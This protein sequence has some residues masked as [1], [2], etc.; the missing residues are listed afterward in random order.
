ML[1]GPALEKAV[2]EMLAR[3]G[4]VNALYIKK[5]AAQVK[6]I[7][8]LNPSSVNRLVA[9]ARM[10]ADIGEIEDLL[11]IAIGANNVQLKALFEKAMEET[12]QDPRFRVYLDEN[13]DALRP[14][15]KERVE[16]YVQTVYRQTAGNMVNL[17]NT[18]VMR[19]AYREAIDR[20]VL[21]TS[22]GVASYTEAMRDTIKQLGGSGLQVQYASGHKRRLDTAVR[23]N[24]VD[25]VNQIN[26]T[27]SV[28][29]GE[30]L[31]YDAIEISAHAKSAPDHEPVQGRVFM[32]AEYEKMQAGLPF[33]DIDGRQ[34]E[35]FKRPIGEWNCR[36]T[37]LAFSTQ[38]SKRKW[39]D[40]QLAAFRAENQQG[41]EIDGK[42]KTQYEAMQMMRDI[43]TEV[44]RQKDI[45]VSA[46]AAGDKALR[47]ECQ[48]NINALVRR[49][50]AI[51]QASG[52]AEKRER[53]TVEGFR[54]VKVAPTK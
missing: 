29:I 43:E 25:A 1:D 4:I 52:N 5:I 48:R 44:R 7:G 51:A 22:T 31:G 50:A 14:E 21:A 45:A 11:R 3:L 12:Y 47:Q 23:Q 36:H 33:Q 24:I 54:M 10:N 42:H 26:K 53:M 2:K 30:E 41:C 18:T 17:S 39:T 27:A 16:R 15:A 13:P 40:E 6:R 20:A 38:W 49:Y 8:E 35:G 9:M 19:Q 37:P 46:Q 32:K 34:F 28:M